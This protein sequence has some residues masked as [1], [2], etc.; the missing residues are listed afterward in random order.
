MHLKIDDQR[1]AHTWMHWDRIVLELHREFHA[2][3]ADEALFI[4]PFVWSARIIFF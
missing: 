1:H 3:I 4:D 2:A